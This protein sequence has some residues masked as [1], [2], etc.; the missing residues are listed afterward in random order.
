MRTPITTLRRRALLVALVVLTACAVYPPDSYVWAP[1]D[2]APQCEAP[3]WKQVDASRIPGLCG[4]FRAQADPDTS[5]VI[6]CLVISRFTPEEAR[7]LVVRDGRSLYEHEVEMHA[8][9]RL[10]HLN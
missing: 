4:N 3:I 1:D 10:K 6:N 9:R 7:R 8:M 2:A 5:C